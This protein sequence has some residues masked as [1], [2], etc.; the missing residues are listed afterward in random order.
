MEPWTWE[1]LAVLTAAVLVN[2]FGFMAWKSD[3][4][5]DW[6]AGAVV[7]ATLAML[8]GDDFSHWLRASSAVASLVLGLYGL[9]AW[10]R[11]RR[12][13]HSDKLSI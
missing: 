8:V 5:G 11:H 13:T 3:V 9:V 10:V 1:V 2:S 4:V 7:V 6:Y 12:A